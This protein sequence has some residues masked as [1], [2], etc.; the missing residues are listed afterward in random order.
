MRWIAHMLKSRV[1]AIAVLAVLCGLLCLASANAQSHS[2]FPGKKSVSKSP[3]GRYVIHNVDDENLHPP[4]RLEL[5]DTLTSSKVKLLDYDRSVDVLWSPAGSKF[6]VIDRAGSNLTE[7]YI[8]I[9]DKSLRRINVSDELQQ[10]YPES[11]R[12]FQNDHV[13][14]EALAWQRE[15]KIKVKV[16]GHGDADPNGF[17]EVFE[18]TLGGD[19]RKISK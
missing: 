16:S 14:V 8:Y 10:K 12:M 4:H 1:P 6:I 7:S 13:Y 17:T 5:E 19:F 15:D 9:V 18:Y 2:T 3:N 11:K